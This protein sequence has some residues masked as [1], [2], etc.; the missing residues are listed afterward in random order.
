MANHLG[1]SDPALRPFGNDGDGGRLLPLTAEQWEQWPVSR[2]VRSGRPAQREYVVEHTGE[3]TVFLEVLALPVPSPGKPLRLVIEITRD[4]TET[5][6]QTARLRRLDTLL[7]EMV[8][9]LSDVVEASDGL[10]TLPERFDMTPTPERCP[11]PSACPMNSPAAKGQPAAESS[12]THELCA[13]CQIT[14]LTHPDQLM[15]L[16]SSLDG[17]LETLRRKRRQLLESQREVLHAERLAAVGEIV[18]GI[19]HQ[20][21]NPVG[22]IL[23]RLDA[24][25]L[26]A[27]E[28]PVSPE[29]ADDLAV[30]RTHIHRITQTVQGLLRFCRKSPRR[31]SLGFDLNRILRESIAFIGEILVKRGIEIDARLSERPLPLVGDPSALQQVFVN[32]LINAADAMDEGGRLTICSGEST[33]APPT[34]HVT[35]TDTGCGITPEV[36]GHIFDPFFTTKQSRGGTGLGLSVSRR[37]VEGLDGDIRV[38]SAPGEGTT[39]TLEVP[40][41]V[42]MESSKR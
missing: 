29:L 26:E 11:H 41:H 42:A 24:I 28:D 10:G 38:E 19:A 3:K 36:I 34:A 18:A 6:I 13:R 12:A 16:A 22:I 30:I 23:S 9:Q 27:E 7:S 32:L 25:E 21:N 14:Q 15:R 31:Q 5:K 2:T 20:I 4:V 39:F 1:R 33:A 37:I 8:D 35:V 40:L 17:L